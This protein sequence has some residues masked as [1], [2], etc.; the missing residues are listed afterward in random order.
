M[1]EEIISY[2]RPKGDKETDI[3]YNSWLVINPSIKRCETIGSEYEKISK[4]HETIRSYITALL[5]R[6][7]NWLDDLQL[8]KDNL[9]R[10]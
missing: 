3:D 2:G 7:E 4:D 6:C 9:Q 1:I 5:T 8:S 10:F